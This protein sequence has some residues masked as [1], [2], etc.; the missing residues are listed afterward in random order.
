VADAAGPTERTR[1]LLTRELGVPLELVGERGYRE[2]G[3]APLEG[4]WLGAF[5]QPGVVLNTATAMRVELGR[6]AG[7]SVDEYGEA[8]LAIARHEGDRVTWRKA[9]TGG[10]QQNFIYVGRFAHGVI[11]GYWYS[12]HIPRFGGVFWLAR[13]DHLTERSASALRAKVRTWSWRRLALRALLAGMIVVPALAP[14][15]ALALPMVGAFGLGVYTL[16]R[17]R[18][19]LARERRAWEQLLH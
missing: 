4:E 6:E 15:P 11:A 16:K 18:D 17:R 13:T 2:P 19:A 3:G 14:A 10:Q 5:A 1:T 12:P 7:S 9:Y 8:S